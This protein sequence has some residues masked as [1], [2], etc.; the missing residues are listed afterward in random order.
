M[1][2]YINEL[3]FYEHQFPLG[4]A[5]ERLI[6]RADTIHF[7]EQ[8]D[9]DYSYYNQLNNLNQQQ[10]QFAGGWYGTSGSQDWKATYQ[11]LNNNE[12]AP[13]VLLAVQSKEAAGGYQ[14]SLESNYTDLEEMIEA[15]NTSIDKDD[16]YDLAKD[17]TNIGRWISSLSGAYHNHDLRFWVWQKQKGQWINITSKVFQLEMYA[18]LTSSFPFLRQ[19]KVEN[20]PN[21]GFFLAEKMYSK[22]GL[23]QNKA[24]WK[25]WFGV[26]ELNG[27]SFEIST[28]TKSIQ[29]EIS[30]NKT[31]RW[32]WNGHDFTLNNLPNPIPWKNEPCSNIDYSSPKKHTFVGTIADTPIKMEVS[33]NDG[34]ILGNYWYVNKSN[35]IF[36]IAGDFEAST[37]ATL[38]FYRLK[39]NV[40]R[41][42]FHAYF[43]DCQFKGWWQHQ[44]TMKTEAFSLKLVQE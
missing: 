17:M 16:L 21:S 33:L 15:G 26:E 9:G 18:T 11:L 19:E 10:A 12:E 44:G 3:P 4:K 34:K 6:F 28:N 32:D 38:R 41:E 24:N 14:A 37:E 1:A 25:H 8:T 22:E 35:S 23:A 20:A 36:P 39:N 7:L 13:V 5:R 42:H 27:I 40:K 31:I 2:T 29:L 43:V 30:K